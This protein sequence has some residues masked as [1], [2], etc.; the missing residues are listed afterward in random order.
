[1]NKSI[2]HKWKEYHLLHNKS[3]IKIASTSTTEAEQIKKEDNQGTNIQIYIITREPMKKEDDWISILLENTA[4]FNMY[5]NW[6][7]AEEVIN[8][9]LIDICHAR[10]VYQWDLKG[11]EDTSKQS[12]ATWM[13]SFVLPRLKLCPSPSN[14]NSNSL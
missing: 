8:E 14:T 4:Y 13:R 3:L 11:K 12:I 6:Q 5:D 10:G 9:K 7:R 1:M 2:L